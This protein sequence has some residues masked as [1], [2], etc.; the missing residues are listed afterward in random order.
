MCK[1]GSVSYIKSNELN[2]P[3]LIE[4]TKDETSEQFFLKLA[5]AHEKIRK[6][7]IKIL[8][9]TKH[10]KYTQDQQLGDDGTWDKPKYF[11]ERQIQH[12]V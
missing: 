7:L 1:Y 3:W 9:I 4:R 8:G 5:H 10:D 11:P 12:N 6:Q 2:L